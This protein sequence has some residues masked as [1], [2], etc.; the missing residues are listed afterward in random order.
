MRWTVC[1]GSGKNH[2]CRTGE[3]ECRRLPE[4][5]QG[6]NFFMSH[7]KNHQTIP[8]GKGALKSGQNNMFYEY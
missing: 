6:L 4:E 5:F 8:I 3:K 7:V 2:D 1:S